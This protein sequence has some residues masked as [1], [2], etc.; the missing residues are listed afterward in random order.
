VPYNAIGKAAILGEAQGFCKIVAAKD[1]AVLGAHFIG[2]RVTELVAEAM[3][4]VGWEAMPDE[5]A[6]LIHP[7]PTLSE[8][9]GEA[10]LSLAGRALHTA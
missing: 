8:S 3:L 4:A 10:A 1:G 7:H 6:Q 5:I 9:F 2:P